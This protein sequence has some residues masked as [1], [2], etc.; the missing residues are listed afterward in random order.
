MTTESVARRLVQ[1]C[2][3][4]QSEAAVTEPYAPDSVSGS[5]T[6]YQHAI[7]RRHSAAL[8]ASVAG[9]ARNRVHGGY[10]STRLA[11]DESAA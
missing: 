11:D 3:S 9:V 4:G 8:R 1:L 5:N 6:Q 2:N 7:G 10:D